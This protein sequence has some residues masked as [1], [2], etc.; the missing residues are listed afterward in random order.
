VGKQEL[1]SEALGHRDEEVLGRILSYLRMKT[2]NDFSHYKRATVLRR[3]A[4]RMQ[5]ARTDSFDEYFGRLRDN[6]Q[7]VEGLLAE[8]LISVTS[9]FRDQEAFQA[10]ARDA[11]PQMF[12]HA[13]ES[14]SLRVWVP[15]CATGEE[16]Y[17]IL[18][19][20]LEEAARRD[21]RPEIQLFASD[22]DPH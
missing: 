12:E 10:L 3:L 21:F 13:Q 22:L 7:E 17:S 6:A 8:L 5:V 11:I 14:P 9:F 16:A 1:A 18:M 2:G 19:L 20:L 15:G 4:R